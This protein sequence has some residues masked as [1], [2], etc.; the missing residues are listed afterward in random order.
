M[1]TGDVQRGRR[2]QRV[3]NEGRHPRNRTGDGMRDGGLWEGQGG[4][5]MLAGDLDTTRYK[6][7]NQPRPN[8]LL[9]VYRQPELLLF[10][11]LDVRH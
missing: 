2:N 9:S 4:R 10:V 7:A 6:I 1:L 8:C 5:D 11:S 3:I